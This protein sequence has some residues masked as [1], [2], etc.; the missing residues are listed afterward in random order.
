MQTP[1][2][3]LDAEIALL[4]ELLGIARA[5][6]EG[7][8]PDAPAI[9][10]AV[11][12]REVLIAELDRLERQA[13]LLRESRIAPDPRLSDRIAELLRLAGLLETAEKAAASRLNVAL[14]TLRDDA[15]SLA[16][17]QE[18]LRTYGGPIAHLSRFTDRKG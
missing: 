15:K 7:E 6:A 18:G 5:L 4:G 14:A 8:E 16:K 3:L 1:E 2:N 13:A 17:G 12:R 11:A 10:A 9:E